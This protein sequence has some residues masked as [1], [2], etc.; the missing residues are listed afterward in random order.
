MPSVTVRKGDPNNPRGQMSLCAF[1][2]RACREE[3]RKKHPDSPVNF[4]EF[5][6]RCLERWETMYAKEKSKFEDMT[7]SDKA[8]CDKEMKNYVPP[9]GDRQERK[10]IPTPLKGLHS[11]AS[12]WALTVTQRS[13]V[14]S[15]GYPLRIL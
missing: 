7:K 15:P 13:K 8:R 4:S 6:K 3:H 2:V 14:N 9:K 5:S 1:F 12:C 11:P 10:K